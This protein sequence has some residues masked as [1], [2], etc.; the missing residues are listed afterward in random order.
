MKT[1]DQQPTVAPRPRE[2]SPAPTASISSGTG[3]VVNEDGYVMTASHVVVAATRIML[4]LSDG[5]RVPAR[6]VGGAPTTDISVLKIDRTLSSH[7]DIS[8]NTSLQP[9]D[10]VFTLGFPLVGELGTE[11]KFTDGSVSSLSG[12]GGDRGFFQLSVPIQPGN[13]GGPVV[14]REGRA[15]GVVSS[16]AAASYFYK[17]SGS[18]PQNVNWAA[19]AALARGLFPPPSSQNSVPKS[20]RDAI[21]LV[22]RSL[23]FIVAEGQP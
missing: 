8:D 19:D 10:S 14:D 3:F 16:T 7:L 23:V 6:I 11:P 22:R 21:A 15:V 13:S 18:M 20:R 5:S 17:R 4:T 12:F 2:R 9:G 1:H